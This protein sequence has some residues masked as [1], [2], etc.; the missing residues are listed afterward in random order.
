MPVAKNAKPQLELR[1]NTKFRQA[2]KCANLL[3]KPRRLIQQMHAYETTTRVCCFKWGSGISRKVEILSN[4]T[5]VSPH[6][7]SPP[8][9]LSPSPHPRDSGRRRLPVLS[10]VASTLAELHRTP[11][12]DAHNSVPIKYAHLVSASNFVAPTT[13][14]AQG[15]TKT[16]R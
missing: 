1:T 7:H 4:T 3:T 8:P 15:T 16:K 6:R 2:R 14:V 9:F 12:M 13:P 10:A 5:A 11:K